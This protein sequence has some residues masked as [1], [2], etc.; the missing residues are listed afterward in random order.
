MPPTSAPRRP[1]TVWARWSPRCSSAPTATSTRTRPSTPSGTRPR[2]WR[3]SP[4]SDGGGGDLRRQRRSTCAPPPP[5][6]PASPPPT[7]RWDDFLAGQSDSPLDFAQ[8]PFDH[9]AVVMFSSGTTGKPKCL[10]QSGGGILLNQLKELILHADLAA[11]RH[12][13]LHHHRELDDVELAHLAVWAPVPPSSSSTATPPTPTWAPS[14]AF[15]E[16][17][18]VTIFGTSASYIN[19]LKAPGYGPGPGLR[20]LASSA[21]SCRRAR[22][23]PPRASP[24][25]TSPSSRTSTSTPSRAAPTSTAASASAPPRCPSTRA[26]SRPGAW[27]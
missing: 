10:V 25:S 16:D 20:P 19:L 3:A 6:P 1:S 15:I 9:P 24:T 13:L 5:G 18:E 27:A 26:S 7:L 2:W 11:G 12:H 17:E 14:G 21:R 8:L 22:P 4:P 23:S